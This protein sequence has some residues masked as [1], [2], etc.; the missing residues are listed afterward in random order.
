MNPK[1]AVRVRRSWRKFQ[2]DRAVSRIRSNGISAAS[3]TSR[4][5]S[6]SPSNRHNTTRSS[7]ISIDAD[8]AH[9]QSGG[10]KPFRVPANPLIEHAQIALAHVRRHASRDELAYRCGGHLAAR[11]VLETRARKRETLRL[12]RLGDRRLALSVAFATASRTT[13]REAGRGER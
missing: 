11:L 9:R 3:A 2:G 6:S 7:R 5:A 10:R 4:T 13:G 8:A 1:Y 12:T